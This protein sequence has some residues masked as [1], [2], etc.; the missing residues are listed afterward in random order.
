MSGQGCGPLH[1]RPLALIIAPWRTRTPDEEE[2]TV[3]A[4]RHL[5]ELGWVPIFAPWALL[6][7]LDD[8]RPPEREAALKCSTSLAWR[9]ACTG[10]SA[11]FV[12]GTRTT[13]G[14]EL[15]ARAWR[16]ATGAN[17]RRLAWSGADSP[18]A[19][20]RERAAKGAGR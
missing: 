5:L 13:E 10:S 15:D 18:E 6:P 14:M 4:A 3:Q 8:E 1:A 19:L 12:V 20:Q 16:D 11:A 7:V 17:P 9:V 2:L